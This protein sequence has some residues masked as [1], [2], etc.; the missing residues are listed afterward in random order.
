MDNNRSCIILLE[1]VRSSDDTA[2]TWIEWVWLIVDVS[3]LI[4][5]MTIGYKVLKMT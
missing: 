5:L 2:E 1:D 4:I 3:S